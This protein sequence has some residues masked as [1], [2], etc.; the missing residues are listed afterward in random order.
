MRMIKVM[1]KTS[2]VKITRIRTTG[3]RR[4]AIGDILNKIHV[5]GVN[6][7]NAVIHMQ[8]NKANI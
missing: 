1:M 2:K 6:F 8:I 7:Q 3:D 4:Q 5:I